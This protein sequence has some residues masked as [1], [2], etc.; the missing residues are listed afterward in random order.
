LQKNLSNVGKEIFV[1][2]VQKSAFAKPNRILI[3]DMQKILMLGN[4]AGGE[5][6]LH[7]STTETLTILKEKYSL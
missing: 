4:A 3:D 7:T 6:I 1:P 5:A 2:A